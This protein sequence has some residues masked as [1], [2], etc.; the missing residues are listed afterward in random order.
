MW[1]PV[2]I[3]SLLVTCSVRKRLIVFPA[4]WGKVPYNAFFPHVMRQGGAAGWSR[5]CATEF[6]SSLGQVNDSVWVLLAEESGTCFCRKQLVR[7][8]DILGNWAH[9]S[10]KYI[11]L[12]KC[13]GIWYIVINTVVHSTPILSQRQCACIQINLHFQVLFQCMNM[14]TEERH[15][16]VQIYWI[17]PPL[18]VARL[19]FWTLLVR[20]RHVVI[21]EDIS[22]R[23]ETHSQLYTTYP[24]LLSAYIINK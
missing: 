11:C 24:I 2:V 6:L 8:V 23:K 13:I 14:R 3:N 20:T 16:V 9:W 12:N 7:I 19:V 22:C 21:T 5:H 18:F 10:E 15:A 1:K 4:L 17:C